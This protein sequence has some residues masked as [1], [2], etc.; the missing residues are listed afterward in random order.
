MLNEEILRCGCL[1][2]HRFFAFIRTATEEAE[3]RLAAHTK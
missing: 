3:R 2:F 1:H